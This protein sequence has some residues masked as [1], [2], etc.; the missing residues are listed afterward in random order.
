M[1]SSF[2][3]RTGTHGE[4]LLQDQI[5]V[6][7]RGS[8]VELS[9][10]SI[11]IVLDALLTL[12]ADLA[13]PY[14]TVDAHP[15]HVLLSELYILGLV[16]DCCSSH[17]DAV[18]AAQSDAE[19]PHETRPKTRLPPPDPL[20]GGLVQ[21]IFDAVKLFLNPIPEGYVLPPRTILDD[22]AIQHISTSADGPNAQLDVHSDDEVESI[23]LLDAR[24]TEVEAQVKTIVEYVTAS[25]WSSAFDFFR[26]VVYTIRTAAPP[27]TPVAASPVVSDDEKGALVVLGLMSSF[28]VDR[29]KLGLVI[30]ELCS[31]FLHF[32]S[33]SRTPSQPLRL[34]SS[35]DGWIDTLKSLCSSM[36]RTTGPMVAQTPCS[37]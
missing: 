8:L 4:H 37:T 5:A 15:A 28:W 21:R 1:A 22:R 20:D 23:S 11:A 12:L 30:Q 29:Q 17:W 14:K 13:R 27:Q 33:R 35:P 36:L 16:A 25:S 7:T 2:P 10:S 34:C 24:A 19:P 3:H 9:A 31:S 18:N 26:N 6:I 32:G